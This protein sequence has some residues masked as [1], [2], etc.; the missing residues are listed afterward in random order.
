[1]LKVKRQNSTESI[2]QHVQCY[3]LFFLL[4]LQ[5]G[6]GAISWSV[7]PEKVEKVLSGFKEITEVFELQNM[8]DDTLRLK[9][10]FEDFVLDKEGRAIFFRAESLPN[11]L[12]RWAVLNPEE[13]LLQP[14]SKDFVRMT[15]RLPE[16]SKFAEYYGMIVFKSLPVPTLSRPYQPTIQVAG[17]IGVPVFYSLAEIVK[18]EGAFEDLYVEKESV[19]VVFKNT[20]NVHLRVKGKKQILNL[21][22]EL[23]EEEEVS[24]FVV[25]PDQVRRVKLPIKKR[26]TDGE[27]IVRVLFDY[28]VVELLQGEAR[29]KIKKSNGL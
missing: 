8:A 4:L 26:L 15:F 3:G 23:V 19:H 24:E 25:L 27:Y 21:A 16:S 20:G 1:M 7:T 6:I 17:E 14:R 5:T 12:A 29:F 28:G 13:V 10:E 11:S 18:R 22:E 9:I 2:T